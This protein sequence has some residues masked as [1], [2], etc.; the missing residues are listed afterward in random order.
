MNIEDIF[1]N[2]PDEIAIWINVGS[3]PLP[4]E[5]YNKDNP[6]VRQYYEQLRKKC[7]DRGWM[8]PD[9]IALIELEFE[10]HLIKHPFEADWYLLLFITPKYHPKIQ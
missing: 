2:D 9:S 3:N 4:D 1:P 8:S 6:A 5:Q 7:I 10:Q